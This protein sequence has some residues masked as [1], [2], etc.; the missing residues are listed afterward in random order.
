VLNT[1]FKI[2]LS[3]ILTRTAYNTRLVNIRKRSHGNGR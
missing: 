1:T 3:I 2:L